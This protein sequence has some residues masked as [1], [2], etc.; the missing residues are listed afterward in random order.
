MMA[1]RPDC[2]LACPS[3]ADLDSFRRA[4]VDV[5]AMATPAAMQ[6]ATGRIAHDGLFEPD[7]SGQRW[8]A[9]REEDAD[10]MVFWQRQTGRLTSCSGRVFALGQEIINET[11]TYSFDCALNIFADPMDWLNARRDGIVVMPN[12]WPAAF[13]RL[14]DCPRIAIAESLLPT[15]RRNM[16]PGRMPELYITPERRT[17]A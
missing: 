6:V 7:G 1:S 4:G 5:L 15:Y 3:Q 10:D 14:R 2:P 11:A 17:A 8:F 12:R 16:T 9:F 13:D